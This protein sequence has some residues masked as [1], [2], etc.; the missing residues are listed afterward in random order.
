MT[1]EKNLATLLST[2]SPVLMPGE[3][4]FCTFKDA[5]YGDHRE[6]APLASF[7][8]DG[9]LTLVLGRNSADEAG[10]VY[11][12]VFKCISLGVHSSLDAVGL[13]AAIS[14]ALA[15]RRISCNVVAAY[16]H[17]HIF[18]PRGRAGEALGLLEALCDCD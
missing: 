7:Q 14:R 5:R 9:G 18:V 4:V 12:T 3:F 13:T 6:L 11:G 15:E 16:Y 1:G 8:E 17:D 2:L 10:C